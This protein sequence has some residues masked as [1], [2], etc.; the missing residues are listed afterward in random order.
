MVKFITKDKSQVYCSFVYRTN[1]IRKIKYV[2]IC[3]ALSGKGKIIG[4]QS[5]LQ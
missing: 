1:G 2:W 4:L 5:Y 3:S